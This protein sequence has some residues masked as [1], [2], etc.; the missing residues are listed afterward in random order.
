MRK[1]EYLSPSSLA[2]WENDSEDFYRNYLADNRA[3]RQSQTAAMAVGSAFDAFVKAHIIREMYSSI[4]KQYELETLLGS[5]VESQN[6]MSV[7]AGQKCFEAYVKSGALADLILE[8]NKSS[9]QPRF[10]FTANRIVKDIGV[11]ILGKP[12][13]YFITDGGAH[14]LLDWKVNGYFSLANPKAGY[15]MLR[16]PTGERKVH[17]NCMIMDFK[18]IMINVGSYLED[19]DDQWA[20]QLATYGW[21]MGE[22]IG[23]DFV[24][25]IEQLACSKNGIRVASHRSRIGKDFQ[26]RLAERYAKLWEIVNSDWIFRDMSKKDSLARCVMLDAAAGA[27]I[28]TDFARVL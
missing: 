10:E 6:I 9:V 3:P 13:C 28:D 7:E 14:V 12:D 20:S 21:L 23:G 25:I 26:I 19:V 18:G 11:P 24:V 2:C 8:L 5:Q 22:E 15:C 16:E 17:K 1:M 27:A 4:A